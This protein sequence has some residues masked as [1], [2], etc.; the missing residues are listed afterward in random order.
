M[1]Q[2]SRVASK[3]S[4]KRMIRKLHNKK[5]SI[6]RVSVLDDGLAYNILDLDKT[7][8]LKADNYNSVYLGKC[9][10]R[11]ATRRQKFRK[12]NYNCSLK[13][14]KH[15]E[16]FEEFKINVDKCVI[17]DGC[18]ETNCH[19][20]Q[21]Q[22]V[23]E[24]VG[25]FSEYP[26]LDGVSFLF[27]TIKAVFRKLRQIGRFQK[28][29]FDDVYNTEISVKKKP[30]MR[31]E[32]CYKYKTKEEA[33][34]TALKIAEK[35]WN[36][37]DTTKTELIKRSEM[38][39]GVYTI[40]ARNKRDYDYDDGELATSRAVHMPE[41]HVELT[42]SPWCD[43]FIDRLKEQSRGSIYIGNSLLD[44]PRLERDICDSSFLFEGDWKRFD[45]TLY[46][47]IITCAL[48][49]MR[50]LFDHHDESIDNH[51]LG[52]YDSL[53]IKDYY[54]PRGKVFRL[55]HGLPSG[56]KSTSLLC[57][58]VNL[59]VLI[60]C[61]GPEKS[62]NFNFIV[63]GDDF[64]VSCK[65]GKVDPET[66]KVQFES[67]AKELGMKLKFLKTKF[68]ESEKIEE[69]PSFYKYCI[70]KNSPVVP[71][72]A[73][74]ERVFMPWNKN[75]SND[76]ELLKFLWNVMPSLGRPFSHLYLYYDLLSKLCF[77]KFVIGKLKLKNYLN[78]IKVSII[79]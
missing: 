48:T 46:L 37:L 68:H 6:Q 8:L 3:G 13:F 64:L 79:K 78:F 72:S 15:K 28:Q 63:G 2:V 74:L 29:E 10:I 23:P 12:P 21:K 16:V 61:V 9:K 71:T 40:G 42:S 36:Y 45:S 62:K 38:F 75:Y 58:L 33:L 67:R 30:G 56:V 57:S 69:C 24:E 51:F 60:Y 41:L 5:P 55:F 70:F 25:K 43:V 66:L 11:N 73:V 53:S 18:Y 39:Y 34:E 7:K 14:H 44:W 20:I 59:I 4:K 54:V 49:I 19:T 32:E 17:I 26:N 31:Y 35:R 50:C 52:M 47:K 22:M 76:V 27:P 65:D 77:I 1:E